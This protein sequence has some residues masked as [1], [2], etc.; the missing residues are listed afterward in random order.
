[1]V[2][3]YC[4]AYTPI[5]TIVWVSP[6]Q[7]ATINASMAPLAVRL[8]LPLAAVAVIA[9]LYLLLPPDTF[10]PVRRRPVLGREGSPSLGSSPGALVAAPRPERG[11]SANDSSAARGRPSLIARGAMDTLTVACWQGRG[12]LEIHYAVALGLSRRPRSRP[13]QEAHAVWC[14][15]STSEVVRARIPSRTVLG[16]CEGCIIRHNYNSGDN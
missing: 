5:S 8:G 12:D 6:Y 14:L 2:S 10:G 15:R 1:M 11:P 7:Q 16:K 13:M 3:K 9:A 4:P